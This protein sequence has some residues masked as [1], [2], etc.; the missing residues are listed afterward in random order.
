[1]L[2]LINIG[3]SNDQLTCDNAILVLLAHQKNVALESE[4]RSIFGVR[5]NFLALANVSNISNIPTLVSASQKLE[6]QGFLQEIVEI[7]PKSQIVNCLNSVNAWH[8]LNFRR[9]IEALDRP[10]IVLASITKDICFAFTAISAASQGFEV[11]TVLDAS[12][13]WDSTAAE[14]A[15]ERTVEAGCKIISRV[16]VTARL[17]KIEYR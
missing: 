13:D 4:D 1:M 10:K 11:Y 15:L 5:N 14:A 16:A 12:G 9:A 6:N 2:D 3:Q 7:C 17:M 8:D